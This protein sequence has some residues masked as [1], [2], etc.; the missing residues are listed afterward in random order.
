[1][2]LQ[3]VYK[4]WRALFWCICIFLCCQLFF[5][6]KGIENAPFFLYNMFSTVHSPKDSLPVLLIKK[7]GGYINPFKLSNREAEM[8]TNNVEYYQLLKKTN[9]TDVLS[10]TIESRFKHRMSPSLYQFAFDGLSND[11]ASVNQY[12]V[13]W[14]S[15]F[16]PIN[17]EAVD[18]VVLVTSYVQFLPQFF[19]SAKDSIILIPKLK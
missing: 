2:F 12:P 4:E 18:S 7:T 13:W 6:Y 19:K 16:T 10:A 1:M 14:S 17:N 15:Y 11:S 9:Y 8:L 3:K 5:M